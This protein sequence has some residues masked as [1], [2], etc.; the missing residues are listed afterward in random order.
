MF[1]M[2]IPAIFIYESPKTTPIMKCIKVIESCTT[3]EQLFTAQRYK[4]LYLSYFKIS[5][6]DREFITSIWYKKLR[7][8]RGSY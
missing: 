6:K 4:I 3:V 5:P 2:F 8:I 1:E 7:D